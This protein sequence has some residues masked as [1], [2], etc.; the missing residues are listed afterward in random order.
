MPET[1]FDRLDAYR[2]AVEYVGLLWP[3]VRQLRGEDR[4]L[5]DQLSRSAVSIP[6]NIGEGAGEFSTKDKARFYRYALRSTTETIAVIDV[7]HRI[8][9]LTRSGHQEA[10]ELATRLVA[11]LTR[12]TVVT[13]Q[14]GERLGE[15]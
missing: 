12:L 13:R 15:G 3:L 5:A 8:G 4:N 6:L 10:R 7:C 11:M 14:R 9:L 2:A 1:H